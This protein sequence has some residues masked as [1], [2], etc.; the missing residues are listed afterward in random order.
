M[1]PTAKVICKGFLLGAALSAS[2]LSF[3]GA[4]LAQ[5]K[6]Q[7]PADA[8]AMTATELHALYAGKSWRWPDGAGLM[9]AENR[10]FSAIA[11]SGEKSSW[12]VGRWTVTDA[13]RLCFVAD[14]HSRSGVFPARTCFRHVIDNGT[15][16][17]RKEPA[18]GW[19]IFKHAQARADDEFTKLVRQDLVSAELA[20]R[21][22][23]KRSKKKP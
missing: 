17:Q 7:P 2:L 22:Q 8:R 18:G 5:G 13:G 20:K 21:Q 10:R 9:E 11:G 15:I 14:W 16:Y 23:S 19:Y 6:S 4:G 1:T 12:A 3:P